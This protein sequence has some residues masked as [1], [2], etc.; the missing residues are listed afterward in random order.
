MEF[1]LL[2]TLRK[3]ERQ[4]DEIKSSIH[5]TQI[6]LQRLAILATLWAGVATLGYNSQGAQELLAG[7]IKAALRLP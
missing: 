3:I 4:M 7:A 5:E 2:D 1:W 6:L